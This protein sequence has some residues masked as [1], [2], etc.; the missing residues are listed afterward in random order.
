[1][2]QFIAIAFIALMAFTVVACGKRADIQPP[3][4]YIQPER[5]Y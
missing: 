4:D 2:R 5:S 1:M 3:A